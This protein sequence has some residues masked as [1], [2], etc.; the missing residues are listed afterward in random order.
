[1]TD[2]IK[3]QL[4]FIEGRK[5]RAY[6]RNLNDSQWKAIEKEI[7][8]PS[9][10]YIERTTLR[11]KAFLE[12]ETPVILPDT[13]I[14]GL[15]TIIDFPDIYNEGEM[16]EIQKEHYVHE[17]G[18]IT[19]LAW[20][21]ENVLKEGLEGR[22]K[23]L[24]DG[25]KRDTEFC[26]CAQET[27]DISIAFADKYAAALEEAGKVE[28]AETLRRIIRNG[29]ETMKEALQ[30]FRMLHFILW[31]SSCY[32]NTVGRFD[33]WLY[34][35]YKADKAN[36]MSDDEALEI[37]EDFFLS[38]NRDSDLYYGLSMGDN[39]QSL[40]LGGVDKKGECVVNELTYL[41]LEAAKE[42]RKIDPKINLRVDKNTPKELYEKATELTKIGLGFPQYSNDD[43]V[44]PCLTHWG[45][46]LEDARNYCIAACW[47]FIIPSVAMDI[48]NIGAISI[49]GEVRDAIVKNLNS[50]DNL[51]QLFEFVKKNLNNVAKESTENLNNIYIEPAPFMSLLLP[52][53]LNQGQDISKGGK[54]NN[55][56][57]HGVGVSCGADQLAAVD[58]YVFREKTVSKERLLT[59]LDN[60][61]QDDA[62]LKYILRNKAEKMGKDEAANEIGNRLLGAFADSF[63]G[64][65]NERGGI[66]RA[67]TGT[68]MFYVWYAENLK[69][70][71]DG[72]EDGEYLPANFSESMFLTGAGPLSVLLGFCL[73]NLQKAG[74]GGPMTLELHDTVFKTEDSTKK[75]AALVKTY[76]DAGGH[77]LQLNAVNRE[78]LMDAQKNPEKHK[79]LIVR[80]W[81]WSGH[82]V[83]LDKSYQNQVIKRLEFDI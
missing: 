74:N 63:E 5:H 60:N 36:G 31:A 12:I 78:K 9:L 19:N 33:M 35:F 53:T 47:E 51:D 17:K 55:Y 29:A 37:I 43:I 6:R 23:R 16:D 10:S 82:F 13:D 39:G 22:R 70:T 15:R 71:A 38:F 64:I 49:A 76:I 45:Y 79:E 75:V 26:R 34:P 77:Q 27:I 57:F 52:D 59:A 56:G 3:R 54:Y 80:V 32:H 50:C 2:K 81:G 67:G 62:E 46:D 69:A 4:E 40:V 1:M 21:V 83:E 20:D 42:V 72:R 61:F 7:C 41:A 28:D 30:L 73:S 25:E 8:N 11:L 66:F 24:L 18:K 48:P 65:K 14:H 58:Q 68:A 44:I